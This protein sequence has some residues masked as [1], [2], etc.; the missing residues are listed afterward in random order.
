[1]MEKPSKARIEFRDKPKEI[2]QYIEKRLNQHN[3]YGL[4]ATSNWQKGQTIGHFES[5]STVFTLGTDTCAHD[6]WA[7]T[8]EK[9]MKSDACL[10]DLF[11]RGDNATTMEKLHYNSVGS[12]KLRSLY[13]TPSFINHS[14]KP[15]SVL[16]QNLNDG[17]C[18][19]QA[20]CHIK[21]GEELTITYVM[22]N[23][24]KQRKEHLKERYGFDCACGFCDTRTV[25]WSR[26]CMPSSHIIK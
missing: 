25:S 26:K 13:W 18:E 21:A 12:F 6:Q 9:L 3:Q 7:E 17:S 20:L 14:C 10:K 16:L 23:D 11:P 2:F 8:I 19:I 4:F 1:M 24:K 15:N 5:I 22:L